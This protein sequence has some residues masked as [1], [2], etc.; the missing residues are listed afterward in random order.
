[1][2]DDPVSRK[3]DPAVLGLDRTVVRVAPYQPA[4]A[5]LF[6]DEAAR[7]RT[8]LGNRLLAIEHVG[9]T[10]VPGLAAKPILDLAASVPSLADGMALLPALQRLGYEHKADPEIPERIYLVKGPP[11]H[12]TH[13]LSLADAGSRFW[14]LHLLFR[15]LL[16]AHPALAEEYARLKQELARQ[17][18]GDR[19]A[20]GAG[21]KAFID[22]AILRAAGEIGG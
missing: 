2:S 22:G 20:Y 16:R 3:T 8:A 5:E 7:L 15:D 9:S 12:R 6:A 17:H 19:R 11:E 13:H 4:W 10:S 1:M 14:R 21:K 18:P